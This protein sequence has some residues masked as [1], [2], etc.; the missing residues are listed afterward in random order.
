MG[1][2]FSRYG[3]VFDLFPELVFVLDEDLSILD[4]NESASKSTGFSAE[5]LNLKP[6]TLLVHK[7]SLVDF[8]RVMARRNHQPHEMKL[9]KAD[10]SLLDVELRIKDLRSDKGKFTVI[11]AK[12]I[13]GQK[14]KELEFLRFSNVIRHTI[15][16]IQITDAKGVMVYVNP[17]FER[18]TGYSKEELIGKNPNILSSGRHGK[19]FWK[20]VW[21]HI[22]AGWEEM[23]MDPEQKIAR[24]RQIYLG[25]DKRDLN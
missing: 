12:D 9:V 15:N 1:A 7:E 8:N 2:P 5:K 17:A 18:V 3:R 23:L 14:E 22:L 21:E 20:E 4:H 11:I 6:F 16:P 10:G 19:D 13:T 25:F 24:P